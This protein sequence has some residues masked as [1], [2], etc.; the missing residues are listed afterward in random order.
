[1]TPF[2]SGKLPRLSAQQQRQARLAKQVPKRIRELQQP[3]KGVTVYRRPEG[4]SD[5][6]REHAQA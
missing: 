5:T 1:M 2:I 4:P 3:G 6:A